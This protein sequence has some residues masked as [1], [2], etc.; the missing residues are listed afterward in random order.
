MNAWDRP[1]YQRQ[2]PA[3]SNGAA[4]QSWQDDMRA[5]VLRRSLMF[6]GA[7]LVLTGLL[8]LVSQAAR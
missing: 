2:A 7:G 8:V 6:L 4:R 1:D 3:Q 5:I